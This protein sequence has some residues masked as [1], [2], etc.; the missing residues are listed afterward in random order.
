M[1]HNNDTLANGF[2]TG[3]TSQVNRPFRGGFLHDKPDKLSSQ[4]INSL[5]PFTFFV[6]IVSWP[7]SGCKEHGKYFGA[8]AFHP[9][10]KN[11]SLRQ[12]ELIDHRV[13]QELHPFYWPQFGRSV[14]EMMEAAGD[15]G[16]PFMY[17]ELSR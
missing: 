4:N 13:A 11:L 1:I 14:D 2:S 12:E 7:G 15:N 5:D 10:E 17:T 3:W 16:S 8:T 9:G 6:A